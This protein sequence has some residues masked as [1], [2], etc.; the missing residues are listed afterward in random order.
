VPIHPFLA[1]I[2]FLDLFDSDRPGT[3]VWAELKPGD[4]PPSWGAEYTQDFMKYRRKCKIYED[5]RDFHSFR[6][7]FI[8]CLRTRAKADPRDSRCHSWAHSVRSEPQR[9]DADR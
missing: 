5:L 1:T 8:T 2:G 7:T 6:H 9:G 4:R 3:R